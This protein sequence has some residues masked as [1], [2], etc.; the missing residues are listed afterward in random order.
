M[1]ALSALADDPP[2]DTPS[3]DGPAGEV[4]T[5]A[6]IASAIALGLAALLISGLMALLL[7]VLVEE[8]RLSA[9]GIGLSAM[10]EALSTGLVTGLAGMVL[11]PV[12]LRT[13]AVVATLLVA[14]AD[15]ATTR[16]SGGGVLAMRAAAGL[17][18]GVLLWISIGMISRSVTP[19]RWAAV[20]FTGM[21]V[22]QLAA[23]AGIS[24]FV[25]P[26]FGANGGY[27]ALAVL[28]LA[29]L[30]AAPFL[31]RAFA[32]GPGAV[33]TGGAPPFRGWVALFATLCFAAALPGVAVYI[34]PL[35]AEAGLPQGAGRLAISVGLACQIAGGV[36]ATLLA[37]RVR[38]AR[39]FWVCAPLLLG[40][41]AVFAMSGPAW[42]FVAAAGLA[43]ALAM[44][45]GPFF[46]P[47]TI[48]ADP[49]R[50]AA[51]QSGAVQLLAGALGPFLGSR[52]VGA[53]DVHGVLI[54]GAA[55]LLTGLAVM[56][57]LHWTARA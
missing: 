24:L 54:M 57:A 43:G 7:G 50:R 3:A 13:I 26:R 45:A 46:V 6:Q 20:L 22:T 23:A 53:H 51:M 21:G 25:L 48:E 40:C 28:V 32:A 33:A 34:L 52:V 55:L 18:E 35:A 29:G 39:V 19:E 37:G 8:G 14:A 15:L 49:S 31:P 1:T 4:F 47:M 44:F 56:S 17:P 16:V 38:Y 36:L 11:K 9:A 27:A 41:W 30:A 5:P 42:L 2:R 12:R 10:L